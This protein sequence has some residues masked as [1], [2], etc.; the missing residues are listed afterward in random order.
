MMTSVLSTDQNNSSLSHCQY[1]RRRRVCVGHV[2]GVRQYVE[3]E[4][5]VFFYKHGSEEQGSDPRPQQGQ[6]NIVQAKEAKTQPEREP[7]PEP[8]DMHFCGF[9]VQVDN[10]ESESDDDDIYHHKPA[11]ESYNQKETDL[12]RYLSDEMDGHVW[13]EDDQFQ[14]TRMRLENNKDPTWIMDEDQSN[15]SWAKYTRGKSNVEKIWTEIME[16]RA[17]EFEDEKK[18]YD[19]V[20]IDDHNEHMTNEHIN[21]WE[22]GNCKCSGGMRRKDSPSMENDLGTSAEDGIPETAH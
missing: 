7:E 18:R 17:A 19:P 12:E 9:M 13:L 21:H 4:E 22:M 5:P 2:W 16:E 20:P 10:D 14:Q 8:Q 6:K 15:I 11:K 1:F 3:I